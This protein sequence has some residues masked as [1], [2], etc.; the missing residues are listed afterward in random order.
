MTTYHMHAVS[1]IKSIQST[2]FEQLT[3]IS[4]CLFNYQLA[5]LSLIDSENQMK[6][7]NLKKLKLVKY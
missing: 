5:I 4:Q 1:S 3:R 6:S 7:H 2:Q